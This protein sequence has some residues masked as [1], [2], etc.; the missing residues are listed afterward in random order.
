M[1]NSV[2]E[3]IG[4]TMTVREPKWIGDSIVPGLD[5]V[6]A[7]ATSY[8]HSLVTNGGYWDASLSMPIT[9]DEG[10]DWAINGL[11]R[12][13]D[14]RDPA[15]DKIFSGFVN[16]VTISV[17]GFSITVGPM[18][19]IVNRSKA[20]YKTINYNT[21]PPLGG[22][23]EVTG[24]ASDAES[25][26][27]YGQL[28]TIITLG[29]MTR[30]EAEQNRN[31]FIEENKAPQASPS[32][33]S[34]SQE[35]SISLEILGYIH[36]LERTH[37]AVSGDTGGQDLSEKSED[38]LTIGDVWNIF[39]SYE[40]QADATQVRKHEPGGRSAMGLM[41]SLTAYGSATTSRRKMFG[42]FQDE[43]FRMNEIDRVPSYIYSVRGGSRWLYDFNSPTSRIDPWNI[44]PGKMVYLADW[45][46]GRP[47]PTQ[48]SMFSVQD[49]RLR[50]DPRFVI[51]ES[52]KFNA[53][54]DFDIDGVK[55]NRPGE[56]AALLSGKGTS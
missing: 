42:V 1:T 53:P 37:P 7:S 18:L 56:L 8:G 24:W 35:P 49:R 21:L 38:M 43:V 30:S 31:S 19:E 6:A 34:R 50:A 52:V 27:R 44:L 9:E 16:A 3:A 20:E 28:E 23:D 5:N 39:P 29:E 51:I 26:A 55:Q 46:T 15:L 22:S 47:Y 25:I 12:H 54:F 36:L 17:G 40:I 41:K 2:H 14:C 48:T 10:E 32:I 33:T 11:G 45:L 13:F 4:L